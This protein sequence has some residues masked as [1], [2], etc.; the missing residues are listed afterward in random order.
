MAHKSIPARGVPAYSSARCFGP[1]NDMKAIKDPGA[2]IDLAN[3]GIP[4]THRQ[5]VIV[6]GLRLDEVRSL[7]SKAMRKLKKELSGWE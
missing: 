1:G 6:T 3:Q 2:I 4:L 7:E 5:L